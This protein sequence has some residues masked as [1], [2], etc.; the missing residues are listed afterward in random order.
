ME[1]YAVV[2]NYPDD[3][4][5][6]CRKDCSKRDCHRHPKNTEGFKQG[7]LFSMADLKDEPDLCPLH[8]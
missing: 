2:Q 5:Y 1:K 6:C 7:S 4:T 3:I 8:S